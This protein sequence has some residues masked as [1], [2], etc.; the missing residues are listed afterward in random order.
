[1][2]KNADTITVAGVQLNTG[3]FINNEWVAGRGEPLQ[4]IDP[5]TE[6]V[7]ATIQTATPEDVDDAVAA[8]RNAFENTWG[9]NVSGQE[10]GQLLFALADQVEQNIERLAALEVVDAGK[11]CAW[12]RVDME[13]TVACLRYYAGWADKIHGTTIEI[14]DKEKHAVARKEPIGVVAQIVPWNYPILMLA[15]KVGPAL[16]AGCSIVFKAAE[17]T[18]LSTLLFAE[19]VRAAGYP[20]GAFNLV[21]GVGAVTGDALARHM[22]VDKIAFTGST[23]TGRRIAVAAAQS[24][25]KAV[26][27]ELGGKSP[28]IVFEDADVGEAAKW[29][30]FGVFENM[31]QSCSAGSRVLVQA[32]VYDA[33]VAEFKR[34]AEAFAVG[35]VNDPK[36]FQGPQVSKLQFDKIMGYIAEGKKGARLVTGGE[37]H[38]SKGYFVQPTVFADVEMGTK[39][40][41]E[42]IFGPV[43]SVIKFGS[44]EEGI[45]IAND[46]SYGLAAAV[47]SQNYARVQR[48][49]RRLKAGT[50]W[51]NQ[52]TLLSHAIP[53]GG[54]KQSGWGRELGAAGLEPY[55]TT[56]SVHHYYGG[57]FEW[58]INLSK[59]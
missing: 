19:L 34:Q 38:G 55:L 30:A 22:D 37:R 1:M 48:V 42:E 59:L 45:K 57:P 54:Y 31:G 15:W 44:E 13:D 21:N 36:T 17:Q 46:T 50:V 52:Y 49:T 58:P 11:P 29:A 8:A 51:V 40:A 6:E 28:N 5:A 20:A 27:L 33:F 7:I 9:T 4:S 39:I 3:L 18:P 24:N 32:G 26:T 16:A 23:A 41:D 2:T 12:A 53:F 43:A 10:R 25:L 56:K 47:H 35:D 14:D